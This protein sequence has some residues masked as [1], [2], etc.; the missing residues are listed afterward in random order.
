[1]VVGRPRFGPVDRI[2]GW[3]VFGSHGRFILIGAYSE[4]SLYTH[5]SRSGIFEFSLS[6]FYGVVSPFDGDMGSRD[7]D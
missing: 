2:G 7:P 5:W 4:L 6:V 1:V 3:T